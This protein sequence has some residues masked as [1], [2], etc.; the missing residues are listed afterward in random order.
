MSKSED[1]NQIEA[2]LDNAMRSVRPPEDVMQRLRKKIG[3]LEPHVI[4]KRLSNWEFTLII[5]GSVMSAAMVIVTIARALY[6]MFGRS[7][8]SA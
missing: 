6:Y 7:E 1:T 4:A 3:Q 5:I 2:Y 8:R